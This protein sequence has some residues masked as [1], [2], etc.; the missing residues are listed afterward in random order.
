MQRTV[1]ASHDVTSLLGGQ[2]HNKFGN[3]VMK[4]HSPIC[5]RYKPSHEK[6]CST[7]Y[8][9]QRYEE[10]HQ[11]MEVICISTKNVGLLP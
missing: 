3:K 4:R 7:W 1:C 2:N 8:W 11:D 9:L 5:Q 10:L 6:T